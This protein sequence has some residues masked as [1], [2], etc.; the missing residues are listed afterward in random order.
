MA[1]SAP[2]PLRLS[3]RQLPSARACCHSTRTPDV[4]TEHCR[5]R[6][7]ATR[8]GRPAVGRAPRQTCFLPFTSGGHTCATTGILL[9]C[10]W[11]VPRSLLVSGGCP[12]RFSLC[13][14]LPQT[15]CS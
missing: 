14:R 3:L 13:C 4:P 2:L 11:P 8:P 9:L 10:F 1:P 5:T 12:V 15:S 6:G 7:A